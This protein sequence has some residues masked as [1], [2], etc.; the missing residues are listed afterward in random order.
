MPDVITEYLIIDLEVYPG[1]GPVAERI[2]KIGALRNDTGETF[3]Q[4]V[5]S[6]SLHAALQA[7]DK[8]AA[9]AKLL[10]GHNIEAFDLPLLR[11]A[12]PDLAL[13]RLPVID[14]LLLSPLAFP[15]NPYHRLVKG[16]K[17]IRDS[18]SSPLSDCRATQILLNDQCDAF[19][20]MAEQHPDELSIYHALLLTGLQGNDTD[21]AF[22][23]EIITS[24][25]DRKVADSNLL[26]SV[27][28]TRQHLAL[29]N[30]FRQFTKCP[31]P[32]VDAI[33]QRLTSLLKE[34]DP[35]QSRTSKVCVT[36][37][38]QLTRGGIDQAL[39]LPLAYTLAWLRVSGGNSV[40]APWVIHQF[41]QVCT[42]VE[43]LR[44]LPCGN[45]ECSYCLSTHDP[46]SELKRYFGFDDFR[47]EAPGQSAQHDV[48]L[49]G[50]RG[51][52]V[53]TVLAT[54][55]G[56]SVCYQLPA[57][58]RYHRNASL[59][60]VIS[61]LQSLMK[62]QVDGLLALNINSAAALNGLLTMPE[63]ADV[64]DRIQMGDIGILLVS[65]EQFRNRG[66][67]RTI[68]QRQIGAWIF[69]E[70]HCLSKWGNDFR[71]DYLYAARY[72][73]KYTGSR[74]LA[75]ISCFTA[76]AKLD[77]LDD[78][79]QHFKQTLGIQFEEFIGTPERPNLQF[80]VKPV[81]TGAKPQAINALLNDH[82]TDTSGG[83]V[84]FVAS[85]AKA[86]DFSQYLEQQQWACAYYHAGLQP[87]E[88]KDIQDSFQRGDLRVITATNAFGM[89]VDKQDVRLVVHADIPGS[90]ENY[91]Q[92]AGRAGRDQ[93]DAWCVLL[94]DPSDIEGQFNLTERSRLHQNDIQQILT[95]L[96][97]EAKRRKDDVL[98][99]TAGEI[100]QDEKTRTSF[101][102]DD[103]DAQTKVV[104]AI[105]WLE[106]SEFV[107]REENRTT[108]YPARLPLDLPTALARLDKAQLPEHR[109]QSFRSILHFLYEADSD[110]LIN[111]D[112]LMRITGMSSD[113]VSS[114]LRQ[115]EQLGV[116]KNDTRI[117]LYLRHGVVSTSSE[118][119]RQ[120]LALETALFDNLP[121]MAPEADDGDWVDL[122]LPALTSWLRDATDI[123]SLL[124]IHVNRL[125][126]SLSQ[127]RDGENRHRSVL[128]L[129]HLNRDYLK[130]RLRHGHR[131]RQL[132]ALGERR[133][134]VS[135]VLLPFLVRKI[136]PGLTGKDIM[137][138]TTFGELHTLMDRDTD[139]CSMIKPD[140]RDRAIQHVLLYLHQQE[141]LTLNH[142][143][144]VMRS[145][146]TISLN[147]TMNDK[148]FIKQHYQ[149]LDEHY[150]ERRIQVHVMREYAEL[151]LRDM[152][153]ALR[154]VMH[155]F[156]D[157]RTR[158]N[159][160]YF[161]GKADILKL[162]TS[163]ASWHAIVEDLNETQRALVTDENDTNS[164]ILAGPGSGKTR[165]IVHRVAYLLRVRRV[166]AEAIIVLTFNRHAASEIR[167]RLHAL[168][169]R[170]AWGLTVMTYHA[171]AMR[172]T[173]TSFADRSEA[174]AEGELDDILDRAGE[175][176]EGN[177][178][179]DGEDDVRDQLLHGYRFV[180]VDEYQDIDERQ[181][182]LIRGLTHHHDTLDDRLSIMAVG[183]D[184]QNI[185]E[186]R[187]GS[188]RHIERFRNEYAANTS[189]LLQ[190]YRS[191][192]AI[193]DCANR[194]IMQNPERLKADHPIHIDQ[195]RQSE[196]A[197]GL[198]HD[199]DTARRGKVLCLEVPADDRS[200][201]NVQAQAVL[202]ELQRLLAL[203]EGDDV[204]RWNGCAVLARQHSTLQPLQAWCE[205]NA[206]DYFLAA[207]KNNALP[208]TRQ[209][210]FCAVIEKLRSTP[211]NTSMNLEGAVATCSIVNEKWRAFFADAH[212][213]IVAEFGDHMPA[214]STLIDWLYE[215]ARTLRTRPPSGLYLGTVHASKGL[216][217]RHV[218]LLDG[219]WKL[220]ADSIEQERRLYYVGMTRAQQT[221]TLS[222]HAGGKSF[223]DSLDKSVLHQSVDLAHDPLLDTRYQT[224]SLNEVDIGYSGSHAPSHHIHTSIAALREGD[225]LKLLPMQGRYFLTDI[226]GNIV[227]RMARSF[228]PAIA[229][230][231]CSVAGVVVRYRRDGNN[232]RN[233]AGRLKC[234][235]W[236]V[237]VPRMIGC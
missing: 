235:Q 97:I 129:K 223:V 49:A 229:E 43:L 225:T 29:D 39:A 91:L 135:Q 13:L 183:D 114:A 123:T 83:A 118:R 216:E 205:Q 62:D 220:S 230:I 52:S 143:M 174:V 157:T 159:R 151:A 8:L 138:D 90:L 70:A 115:M 186:W 53:L 168:V 160:R 33:G 80:E 145:A 169:E 28:H 193:I 111:T 180:L 202:M 51:T 14:T 231:Q 167:M 11:E 76:T 185:Y 102:A 213:Q 142:G 218:M 207:D 200:S 206:V 71:P 153:D 30:F 181:Y 166:P 161:H 54:G 72:I 44:D 210:E 77:V 68:E 99:I 178:S 170:D 211:S 81:D 15:Q 69:D 147:E 84:V 108:I 103:S 63:R 98:I 179:V 226:D 60:I 85:R 16:Y 199:R 67:R 45:P 152:A 2:H 214:I 23:P 124:P 119:L 165:V 192:A 42:L 96:R 203:E 163:E 198:W 21:D 32:S 212:E 109:Q 112:T 87:N 82:L 148:R 50:M 3:E 158:F 228:K 176:L 61:P 232:D 125:L 35:A 7:V 78:I 9:G 6:K 20:H 19:T 110:Q 196:P 197:G 10:L 227:G 5:N 38:A 4:S 173:G 105:A 141:V 1:D 127:D 36:A 177:L 224:V 154:L 107:Q 208:L 134:A 139:L 194:L 132:R 121:E 150:R 172:L 149:K 113:I 188:N 120:C 221:L 222:R 100:L 106:R 137:V 215:Y 175:L 24:G 26:T 65:P 48:V 201:G 146:M 12:A 140:Q 209:R 40:L 101:D 47:Y 236:E 130:L 116:L 55:G 95:K 155:Y 66:F 46:R 164:L 131:W 57:L 117:T 17:L 56:K 31:A 27:S 182:R 190:N 162:A 18:L 93:A 156:S 64:L 144:S 133:R 59:S 136:K 187:G 73:K 219:G 89:G 79:R 234:D 122:N 41:P 237:I 233:F 86:E 128:E 184:D 94:Y 74:R 217:F 171:M 75:P 58:N 22:V 191:S 88:K 189:Y 25:H 204:E 37:L 92:E 104:T 126:L 34:S 195:H